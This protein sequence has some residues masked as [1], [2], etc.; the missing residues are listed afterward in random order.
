MLKKL[1]KNTFWRKTK[2]FYFSEIGSSLT[3]YEVL[4]LSPN[5]S[6]TEIRKR[7]Y[8]LVKKAHPDISR[9][10]YDDKRFQEIMKAYESISS[11]Q[12]RLKYDDSIGLTGL[13][14]KSGE[15]EQIFEN[16]QQYD[17]F[18]CKNTIS[19]NS[20]FEIHNFMN[21]QDFETQILQKDKIIAVS[22]LILSLW[23]YLLLAA[24]IRGIVADGVS[25]KQGKIEELNQQDY[26]DE[27][28]S[29]IVHINVGLN[30][31]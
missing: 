3:A 13:R 9:E 20:N 17:F 16:D 4:E 18:I 25:R 10:A 1:L 14:H 24:T 22:K 12:K 30:V 5:S 8:E 21:A 26:E 11:E 6:S 27:K 2:F 29:G 19:P 7:Y 15:S 31:F 23:I 28:K